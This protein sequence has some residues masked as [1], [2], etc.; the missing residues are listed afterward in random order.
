MGVHRAAPLSDAPASTVVKHA[1]P[2]ATPTEKEKKPTTG[3][4]AGTRASNVTNNSSAGVA[5]GK[6]PQV[7]FFKAFSGGTKKKDS[8]H[9]DE[10]TPTLT[11]TP[12]KPSI[13]ESV[14]PSFTTL[15]A[16]PLP[17][18]GNNVLMDLDNETAD[19]APESPRK[20]HSDDEPEEEPPPGQVQDSEDEEDSYM[21]PP[22][23]KRRAPIADQVQR[24]KEREEKL[25]RMM[26]DSDD[27]STPASKQDAVP[28]KKEDYDYESDEIPTSAQKPP[29]AA[30]D[31]VLPSKSPPGRRRGRRK[32]NKRISTRDKDGYLVVSHEMVWESYSEDEAAAPIPL[33]PAPTAQKPTLEKEKEKE[34]EGAVPDAGKKKRAAAAAQKKGQGQGNIMNFFGKK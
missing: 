20:R 32:V 12:V 3:N 27:D 19:S 14:K 11:A 15:K 17:E 24:K 26:D 1:L 7:D 2:S 5:Q 4:R 6:R 25:R 16:D 28:Y 29:A 34:R 22:L 18:P 23:T 31:T 21:S 9:E 8:K 30:T 33:T 10:P 13:C